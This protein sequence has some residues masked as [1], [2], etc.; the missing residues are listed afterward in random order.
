MRC[1]HCGFAC[2]ERGTDMSQETFTNAIKLAA[3]QESYFTL[4]GGEPLLHPLFMDFLWQSIRLFYRISDDGGMPAVGLVTNGKCEKL[5][6]EVARMAKA[7]L[8]SARLSIDN[9]HEPISEKVVNAFRFEGEDDHYSSR[10]N[11]NDKDYRSIGGAREANIIAAG[12]ARNWGNNGKCFCQGVIISPNGKIWHCSC[13]SKCYGN[14]NDPN[15]VLPDYWY[16]LISEER[17][18][19][20]FEIPKPEKPQEPKNLVL[21]GEIALLPA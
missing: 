6:L 16:D 14:V 8:L 4:G 21:E 7:G 19:Q 20:K 17:C 5:A 2:T 3:Q 9:Y 11:R 18:F 15:L 1:R 10:N 13:K 12:R